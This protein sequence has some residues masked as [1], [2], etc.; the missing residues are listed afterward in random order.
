M[1]LIVSPPKRGRGR[2]RA[3]PRRRV[4]VA[5]R[6]AGAVGFGYSPPSAAHQARY[7]FNSFFSSL[8]KRQSV[9]WAMIF[10]G[11]ALIIPASWS[12]SA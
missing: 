9:P 4:E 6:A 5:V 11:V 8:R 7:P 1:G 2:L 12:R 10:C 3:S